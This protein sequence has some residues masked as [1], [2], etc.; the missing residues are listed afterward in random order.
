RANGVGGVNIVGGLQ[1]AISIWVDADKL[2]ALQL[3]VTVVRDAVV[4]QN[5]DIPGGNLTNSLEE[6]PLR[7][8]ARL[9]TAEDFNGIVITKINGQVIYLR[10]VGRAE[11]GTKEQ[12]SLS[13]LNGQPTVI[14]EVRRQSGENTVATI[15]AVKDAMEKVQTQLPADVRMDVIRD[16]S[17]Y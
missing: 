12:R 7:L 10:D 13:T 17:R 14:L 2:A 8:P 1:R 11:D 9:K 4:R 15:A 16:Q 3:P 6:K 5:A